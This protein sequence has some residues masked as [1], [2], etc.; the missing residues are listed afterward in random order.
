MTAYYNHDAFLGIDSPGRERERVAY[1]SEMHPG[2]L[3]SYMERFGKLDPTAELHL[4]RSGGLDN[5]KRFCDEHKPTL[6][7]VDSLTL[8]ASA[9]DVDQND[10]T[11][12]RKLQSAMNDCGVS[13]TLTVHHYRKLDNRLRGSTDIEASADMLISFDAPDGFSCQQ[14]TDRV[15]RFNGRFMVPGS[16]D[17]ERVYIALV[18]GKYVLAEGPSVSLSELA[19]K[20][21]EY[22]QERSDS[23]VTLDDCYVR[24]HNSKKQVNE[25]Y[26][27]VVAAGVGIERQGRLFLA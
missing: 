13:S 14:T 11:S 5:L 19:R 1:I 9:S 26:S 7:I 24:L 15:M 22:L 23:G 18:D 17:D 20:I 4:T 3:K 10:A 6:V 27:E 21:A 25:A 8:L 16:D 2:R 12:M